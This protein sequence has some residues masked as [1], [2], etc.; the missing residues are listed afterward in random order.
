MRKKKKTRF[1]NMSFDQKNQP[2]VE[3]QPEEI[4]EEAAPKAPVDDGALE[5]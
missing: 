1:G 3:A 5:V 2:E 4:L